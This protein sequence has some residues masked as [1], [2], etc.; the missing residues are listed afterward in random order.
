MKDT[1]LRL[2]IRE[3]MYA[4]QI[5]R[6]DVVSSRSSECA[7]HWGGVRVSRSWGRS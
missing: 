3:S 4:T 1:F 7:V 2:W 5:A 6:I